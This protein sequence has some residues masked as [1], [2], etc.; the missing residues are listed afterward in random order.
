MSIVAIINSNVNYSEKII[1][2]DVEKPKS[3]SLLKDPKK[4]SESDNSLNYLGSSK[5]KENSELI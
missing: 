4:N 3:N 1:A 5:S 2:D